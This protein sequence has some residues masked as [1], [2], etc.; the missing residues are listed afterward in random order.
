MKA[1]EKDGSSSWLGLPR[2]VA[3][4]LAASLVAGAGFLLWFTAQ[5]FSR[6]STLD[7]RRV[8]ALNIAADY[9][10]KWPAVATTIAQTSLFHRS[11]SS[12]AKESGAGKVFYAYLYHPEF[13]D[14][15][16][17]YDLGSS[18]CD[19]ELD[20]YKNRL[21]V[22]G[23]ALGSADKVSEP[24]K[25]YI[26]RAR[27]A[28]WVPLRSSGDRICF[29]IANLD[30]GKVAPRGAFSH[31]L[32]IQDPRRGEEKGSPTESQAASWRDGRVVAWVGPYELPIRRLSDLPALGSE[33]SK[34]V[35]TAE[36]TYSAST[37]QAAI[38]RA[39]LGATDALEPFNSRIAGA[40]YRFY[41]RPIAL[42]LP[43]EV[44]DPKQQ[45]NS[46]ILVGV[47]PSRVAADPGHSRTEVLAFA[48]ALFM[49]IAL[50][51]VL[52]LA[53][54][55]PVDSMKAIEVAGICFGIV[56]AAAL[57]TALWIG[58][59][60]VL[61]ARNAALPE[62][63]RAAA[64]LSRNIDRG[65]HDAL[66]S[67]E[68]D[69]ISQ[70]LGSGA[71]NALVVGSASVVTVGRSTPLALIENLFLLD[72]NGRQAAG[73]AMNAARDHVGTNFD[74]SDRVYFRRAM[75]EDFAPHSESLAVAR[76]EQ[77]P[78]TIW[79]D[80]QGG[81]V[82]E[83]V[84]SRTDGAPKTVVA[85]KL[86]QPA[87]SLT[88]C[89]PK[90]AKLIS[91]KERLRP[92]AVVA[93]IVLPSMLS[94]TLDP[95]IRYAVVDVRDD[96]VGRPVLF[97][98]D[99]YRAG[100]ELFDESLDRRTR[101]RLSNEIAGA[102]CDSKSATTDPETNDFTGA[103][104][105]ESTLFAVAR[106]PCTD[107]AVVTF[108]SRGLIDAQAVKP[109]VYAI[110]VWASLTVFPFFLWMLAASWR[111]DGAWVWLWPEPTKAKRDAY[112][113]LALLLAGG[114]LLAVIL[115][116]LAA[117]F[118][119]FLLAALSAVAALGW[120]AWVHI[121]QAREQRW[122]DPLDNA[123][124]VRF[125]LF[126]MMLIIMVSLVPVAALTS[127]ARAYFAQVAAAET[128]ASRQ[129]SEQAQA[130]LQNGILRMQG[131]A[132]AST[133]IQSKEAGKCTPRPGS[134]PGADECASPPHYF[135][136][137]LRAAAGYESKLQLVAKAPTH[138]FFG[139]RQV[140]FADRFTLFSLALVILVVLGF[141]IWASL[142]GLFGF[143]VSLEAIE[144]PR[145]PGVQI[146]KTWWLLKEWV[147]PPRFLVIRAGD[148]H[149]KA[150]QENAV[151]MD[152]NDDI[153][154]ERELTLPPPNPA[155]P[156][157]LLIRNLGLLLGDPDG[158]RKALERL[159]RILAKQGDPPSYRIAILTSLTPL[160]RLLQSYERERDE[161]YELG[162]EH[163]T[164]A[165]RERAKHRE[166]MRWS[167]VFEQFTT[168]YH[169]A[170]P[171]TA[172][173]DL[174]WEGDAVKQIWRELEYVPDPVVAAM[175]WDPKTPL[176]EQEI[177]TWARSIAEKNP[178]PQAIVDHLTSNLIEHYHLMWSLSSRAERLLLY[179]IA[180][181]HIPNVATAYMLRSLVKRGLIVLDPY[182]RTMNQSFAQFIRHAEKPDTIKDWRRTQQHG[183]W[184]VARLLFGLLL[185]L[186]IGVLI[187][188][189]IRSGNSIVS[190][191]PLIVAAGPALIN[192]LSSAR[193]TAAA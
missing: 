161:N 44:T 53:L 133:D 12:A 92:S 140:R 8:R 123:T 181:D 172:P 169:A 43:G 27:K 192:A 20:I 136:E 94:P 77:A 33:V 72:A 100:V 84:R 153:K 86:R 88:D 149:L 38:Q 112:G 79:N 147:L 186:A 7:A 156:R 22:R 180:H 101:A 152:L 179:R 82:F 132:T 106:V 95:G 54:L 78:C 62:V 129:L 17:K 68:M 73:T 5:A 131:L 182:P 142:R 65:L 69:R 124:E 18:K 163:Q 102:T 63:A 164:I 109:L 117:P 157:L 48:F 32:L 23:E 96:A 145:L 4:F 61:V 49:L 30:L 135:T 183:G 188:A 141:A 50:M 87:K 173:P 58:V 162:S 114:A 187:V 166:D 121:K 56:A 93:G 89:D 10:A 16:V 91:N 9:I 19:P 125:T 42:D 97:H 127:D 90:S 137:E 74:L 174:N 59:R 115:M 185:P 171:R 14:F 45:L 177:L 24:E 85:A 31:L 60:D 146:T 110:I 99:A 139:P 107:W 116:E 71:S 148:N 98:S 119:A 70:K 120:L 28:A 39:D 21:T 176:L 184:D 191:I 113:A 2:W 34:V 64:S 67:F 130:K 41:W 168:Y 175:M 26:E 138:W 134:D 160:E 47:V 57:G 103:Y 193:R 37:K 189:A 25:T 1:Q 159:E 51:P 118:E 122:N 178:Q 83:Q 46:Y 35:A 80:I 29:T 108:K 170:R 40:D 6:S 75:D 150:L 104:E 190:I 11:K 143:G 154:H 66:L 36:A 128:K 111:G 151:D 167:A 105:Q 158:R 126:A 15:R 55:G 165:R 52:K 81:L 13:G 3:L 76:R 144:Y 155:H